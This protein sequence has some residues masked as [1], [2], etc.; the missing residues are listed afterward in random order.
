M[1]RRSRIRGRPR[2]APRSAAVFQLS[3]SA[4]KKAESSGQQTVGLTDGTITY[5]VAEPEAIDQLIKLVER[6]RVE[7]TERAEIL[8]AKQQGLANTFRR[9]TDEFGYAIA[10]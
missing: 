3:G 1:T 2:K 8:R 9:L 4:L 6:V 10:S 7:E 5:A